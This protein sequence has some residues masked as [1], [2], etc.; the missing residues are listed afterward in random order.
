MIEQMAACRTGIEV[1][2]QQHGDD[3]H[4]IERVLDKALRQAAAKAVRRVG[5]TAIDV[6]IGFFA[7][8]EKLGGRDSCSKSGGAE[9]VRELR[10]R[11]IGHIPGVSATA[12]SQV[13]D[14]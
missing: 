7:L 9:L 13:W 5:H 2:P 14:N 8:R 6:G 1:N 11:A 3:G 10:I 12:L 4:Q